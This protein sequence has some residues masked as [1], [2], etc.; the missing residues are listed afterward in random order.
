[1]VTVLGIM[2]VGAVVMTTVASVT[3][4]NT[5]KTLE[6]RVDM[7]ARASADAGIDIVLGQLEGRTYRQL[8]GVCGGTY[9]INNDDVAVTTTYTVDRGGVTMEVGCPV[10]GDLALKLA[11]ES[12][13]TTAPILLGEEGGVSKTVGAILL[14]TPPEVFLDKAIFSEGNTWIT[15]NSQLEHSGALDE[16]GNPIP[17]ANVYSNGGI[18]CE[19]QAGAA[20]SI[21]AAHG[22]VVI[23]N[24]CIVD[25]SVWASG[26]VSVS[27]QAVIHGDVYAASNANGAN[28]SDNGIFM[29]QSTARIDGAALTNG[30]VYSEGRISQGGGIAGSILARTGD[31]KLLNQAEIGGSAYAGGDILLNKSE[32]GQDAY[33]VTGDITGS[34]GSNRIDGDARAGGTVDPGISVGGG[35]PLSDT[36]TSAPGT[37][38]PA[39]VFPPAV[40]YPGG[41]QP[42]PREQMP[43]LTMNAEDI[44]RWEG[45][46]WTV[47]PLN[48][49]CSADQVEDVIE[50]GSW[51]THGRLLIFEGCGGQVSYGQKEL[52]LPGNLALVSETGF[53]AGAGL[54]FRSDTPGTSRD[55]FWIVPSD[56]PNVSWQPTG[57]QLTPV[58]S[59]PAPDISIDKFKMYDVNLMA[60]TPCRF[61]WNTG[62]DNNS[63]PWTGQI[64]AGDVNIHNSFNLKMNQMPVPSLVTADP[65]LDDAAS[66]RLSERYDL[67]G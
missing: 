54:F 24:T 22:D 57:S 59:S 12:T 65:D 9:V 5:G 17:D 49:V 64:Y 40:G 15:N 34:G 33:T 14:P 61:N 39:D 20:G 48:G 67:H 43:M 32:I 60:Y 26:K 28:A 4:F 11:V 21:Y 23:E 1:M 6:T 42:P 66:M 55:V 44:S 41:I 53:T 63:D 18:T 2:L 3:M 58:C 56:S 50:N 31:I 25:S 62:L 13:A 27:S 51:T 8:S 38:S 46:G 45:A 16:D 30:G 29:T 47:E 37:P 19:T 10:D 52:V 35:P 36:P 7:R